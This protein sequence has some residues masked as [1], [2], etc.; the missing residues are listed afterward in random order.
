MSV[1]G[2]WIV[3]RTCRFPIRLPRTLLRARRG[4]SIPSLV[5]A[6][7][8]CAHVHKYGISHLE[9]INFQVPDPFLNHRAV[10]YSVN[11]PCATSACPTQAEIFVTAAEDVSVASLLTFWKNW[12]I[13]V[14]C[15][16]RHLVK[17]VDP[18]NWVIARYRV[19]A[20]SQSMNR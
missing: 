14:R 11:F 12:A 15:R 4:A 6:C 9:R 18:T 7:P 16:T 13:H 8:I 10:L 1:D 20:R 17:P 3:C 5:L 19:G 2:C